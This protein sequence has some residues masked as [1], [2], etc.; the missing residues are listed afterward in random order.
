[1]ARFHYTCSGGGFK[2]V[3]PALVAI[4]RHPFVDQICNAM[5][6]VK[7]IHS[8]QETKR[9]VAD[10]IYDPPLTCKSSRVR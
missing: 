7:F 6:I 5:I 8:S 1:M 9:E 10:Q 3:S 4:E 2:R